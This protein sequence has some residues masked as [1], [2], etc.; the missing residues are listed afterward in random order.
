MRCGM[1]CRVIGWD[2]GKMLLVISGAAS[3]ECGR[4]IAC[5]TGGFAQPAN[6]MPA[7]IK[8]TT[9]RESD[10]G[11]NSARLQLN[12]FFADYG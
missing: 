10:T 9:K 7:I 3:A 8:H 1:G 12:S 11:L 4:G 5:G 2:A 6:V